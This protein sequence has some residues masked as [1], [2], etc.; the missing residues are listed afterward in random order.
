MAQQTEFKKLKEQI[1]AAKRGLA[2][3]S[4]NGIDDGT[5]PA[6]SS[7][8]S[9]EIVKQKQI[10]IKPGDAPPSD[11]INTK[12]VD[13][14]S[15]T[16]LCD[17]PSSDHT[18]GK[19]AK[20]SADEFQFFH[21]EKP[22]ES[23]GDFASVISL[24]EAN[25]VESEALLLERLGRRLDILEGDVEQNRKYILELINLLSKLDLRQKP[26]NRK[27][28]SSQRLNRRHIFWLVIGFLA[29]GWFGLTPS[30]HIAFRHFLTFM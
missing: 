27:L 17:T 28:K 21:R 25:D 5:T 6:S 14:M 13:M 11:S 29:V 1:E 16:V 18:L 24:E 30:G 2:D 9:P 22:P 7:S 19:A 3:M 12:V 8:V 15:K 4:D 23:I 10:R 26:I 20:A